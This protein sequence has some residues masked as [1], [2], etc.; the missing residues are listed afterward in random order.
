M[1]P[2]PPSAALAADTIVAIATP[3][4][5][6]AVGV[7]RVS[8]TR[9]RACAASIVRLPGAVELESASPRVLHRARLV[10]PVTDTLV[11]DVLVVVMAAPHSYTG[12]DVVELSCHGNPL[13]LATVVSRL[14]DAGARLA[15]PGE[16]TRRAYLNG[17]I[18]LLQA[19]SVAAL[20]GARTE[21]AMRVAARQLAGAPSEALGQLREHLLDLMAGLEVSLDFPDDE[22]GPS[23]A[24]ALRRCSEIAERLERLRGRRGAARGLEADLVVAL[25]GASNVGKSSLLNALLGFDRAIV[26]PEPGTTRDVVDGGVR[27]EGLTLRVV[28]SAGLGAPRDAIDAEGMAR[29]RRLLA[30]SDLTIVVLDLSRPRSPDDA[31]VIALVTGK[32]TIVVANKSDLPAAWV[33]GDD[34]DCLSSAVADPGVQALVERLSQWV[35]KRAAADGE[36]G[37]LVVSMRVLEQLDIAAVR[38]RAAGSGLADGAPFEAVLV[39]LSSALTSL[40]QVL[41]EQVEE[42]VLERIFAAFCV[43]K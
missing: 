33:A 39:D 16:F 36:D 31:A 40:G 8:G 18:D 43:G 30:E 14:V 27:L 24:E 37:G 7:V 38:L 12:E 32:E 21:R 41:G 9:A 42:A 17:R 20:I 22:V 34:V 28:D 26:S 29:T 4:G 5:V 15:E 2:V 1:S 23:R 13:I 19:E 25:V 11:D 10:D 35:K 3:P 6:G